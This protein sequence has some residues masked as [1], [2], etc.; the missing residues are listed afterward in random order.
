MKTDKLTL[1]IVT[2]LLL[3]AATISL[4][5]TLSVAEVYGQE[6]GPGG[7]EESIPSECLYCD[8]DECLQACIG[9]LNNDNIG[10]F[11]FI[12]VE[13]KPV[14]SNW[15][16]GMLVSAGANT[17]LWNPYTESCSVK[18]C[19]ING[20]VNIEIDGDCTGL[21]QLSIPAP[22]GSSEAT[23]KLYQDG[24]ELT[25]F[26]GN[27]NFYTYINGTSLGGDYTIVCEN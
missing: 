1:K 12:Y 20:G 26:T 17:L 13:P 19:V 9:S 7:E 18:M 5:G 4:M 2:M 27:D 10:E 6:E 22:N 14:C 16:T 23:C 11:V 21:A 8:S 15:E 25:T 24:N 3:A